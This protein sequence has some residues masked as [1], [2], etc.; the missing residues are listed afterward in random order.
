MTVT[1]EHW[2]P[3]LSLF[4]QRPFFL[5]FPVMH[6]GRTP[7]VLIPAIWTLLH[8]FLFSEDPSVPIASGKKPKASSNQNRVV[9]VNL[10]ADYFFPRRPHPDDFFSFQIPNSF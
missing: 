8:F 6:G 2:T 3:A 9:S 5:R 1:A 10:K 4:H 7:F